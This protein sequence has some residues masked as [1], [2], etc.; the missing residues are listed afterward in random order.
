MA[1]CVLGADPNPFTSLHV[2]A[3]QVPIVESGALKEL[4]K[5]VG[6]E[7]F[8]EIQCHA[9]GT[10]RNLAAENQNQVHM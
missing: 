10:L 2:F 3:L 1:V 9:A 6:Q 8:H 5:L 4:S 7:G